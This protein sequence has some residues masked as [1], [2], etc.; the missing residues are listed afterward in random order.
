[1]IVTYVLLVE[2]HRARELENPRKSTENEVASGSSICLKNSLSLSATFFLLL[3]ENSAFV[4]LLGP[5][6]D[7]FAVQELVLHVFQLVSRPPQGQ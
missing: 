1:M 6:F 4:F 7:V 3:S 5:R 2:F